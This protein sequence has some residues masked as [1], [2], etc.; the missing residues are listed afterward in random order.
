MKKRLLFVPLILTLSLTACGSKESNEEQTQN[1][2][3]QTQEVNETTETSS[4][5]ETETEIEEETEVPEPNTSA[6]VDYLYYQAK[7]D[8]E[9]NGFSDEIK[10]EAVKFLVDNYPNYFTDNET[11]EKTMY[12]GYYLERGFKD[13][14]PNHYYNLGMDAN[15]VVRFVYRGVGTIEDDSTQAN[16]SQIK[17]SLEGLGFSLY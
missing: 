12:Y 15:Q 1:T 13:T 16:L 11:M 10:D 5:T 3:Q 7:D 14:A 2:T 6:M 4:G 17:K 8:I 9:K